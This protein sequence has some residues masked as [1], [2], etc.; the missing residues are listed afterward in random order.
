MKY[1]IE[2]YNKELDKAHEITCRA[3]KVSEMM[4]PYRE[5]LFQGLEVGD[6]VTIHLWTDAHAATIIRR[7]KSTIWAR[8]DRAIRTDDNGMSE[9]QDYRFEPNEYGYVYE[10]HW[11]PKR[12]CFLYMGKPLG[13]GRHEYYDFSF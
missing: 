8:R 5:K 12:K 1:S 4:A 3:S 9:S 10:C 7:T 6:G 11:S 2:E 13:V